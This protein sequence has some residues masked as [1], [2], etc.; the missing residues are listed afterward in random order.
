MLRCH[1]RVL[2][3]VLVVGAPGLMRQ[4]SAQELAR[5]SALPAYLRDRGPGVPASIFGTYIRR[6]QLLV[7]P[8]FEYALDNNREYQ[9][10]EFGFG[11]GVDLRA[12]FHSYAGQVFIGYGVT[13]WL[14]IEFE[15]SYLRAH[16]E[17]SPLDTFATPSVIKESGVADIEAHIRARLWKESSG[18]PELYGFVEVTPPTQKHKLLIAEP[19]F[20]LK[21]GIGLIKGFSWGTLTARI[22]A[23]Y[24]RKE[25]KVDLGEFSIEY[26]KRVSPSLRGFLSFEGG[27]TGAL[28][29]WEL[30]PGLQW[31][32]S[33]S[34]L[35]KLDNSIGISSKVTD[36]TPQ[37][38][39]M[40]S[41]QSR[42][43]AE[44]Q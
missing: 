44:S 13:D 40:F 25:S 28:D 30:V 21:P 35:F 32:I 37:I 23:E 29:E 10:F 39:L 33:K 18:R 8:F 14:A 12:K 19:D 17:K 42:G 20:D 15:G 1:L 43:S 41:Y 4:A 31:Q 24:N 7:Y 6:G 16:F 11:P 3:L 27:E 22:G 34:V 38:G 5:D 26:L 9:P 2:T 36:W